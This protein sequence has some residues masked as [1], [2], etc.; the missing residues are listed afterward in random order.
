MSHATFLTVIGEGLGVA[1]INR[2]D[3]HNAPADF[4]GPSARFTHPVFSGDSLAA[5]IWDDK[6]LVRFQML[7]AGHVVLDT[8]FSFGITNL[9]KG[10]T[11]D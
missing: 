1:A 4:L 11:S 7:A 5:R 6:Y 8:V 3:S 2:L 9:D 10:V